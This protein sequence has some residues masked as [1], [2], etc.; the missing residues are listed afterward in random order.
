MKSAI[1]LNRSIH[2]N[3]SLE[4]DSRHI[5][6]Y[7]PTEQKRISHEISKC[8]NFLKKE[9]DK[10]SIEA[11]DY[12]AGTGNL[13]KHFLEIG[14]DKVHAVDI[15]PKSLNVVKERFSTNK[16]LSTQLSDGETLKDFPDESVEFIGT[17]SVLHHVPDYLAI[18]KEFQR[19]L[20]PGGLIYIDHEVEPD[21]WSPSNEYL[22]YLQELR[23][24]TPNSS[25]VKKISKIFSARAWRR[26]YYR[27]LMKG[28]INEEGDIHVHPDDHIEWHKIVELLSE[29]SVIEQKDYLVCREIKPVIWMKWKDSCTDMRMLVV[30]KVKN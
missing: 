12:G 17:Y 5:E 18:I 27:Y 8:H 24:A 6:I 21:Y 4:Y 29:C 30:Q 1:E 14:F 20:K 19:V 25:I 23:S 3:I 13:T 16:A 22:E 15:S 9:F 11:L 7:N 2:D 26:I 10:S 28:R